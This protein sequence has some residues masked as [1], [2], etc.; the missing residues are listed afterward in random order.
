MSHRADVTPS[1]RLSASEFAF[2][3]FAGREHCV[4]TLVRSER[5]LIQDWLDINA[6]ELQ[7][8]YR[9]DII[10]LYQTVHASGW[11]GGYTVEGHVRGVAGIVI[12]ASIREANHAQLAVTRGPTHWS[13]EDQSVFTVVINFLSPKSG[14]RARVQRLLSLVGCEADMGSLSV[15]LHAGSAWITSETCD[16]RRHCPTRT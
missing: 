8:I 13:P 4:E 3:A 14:A 1:V 10:A 9:T 11:I 6:W 5:A 15:T 12:G 7:R 16:R 2:L